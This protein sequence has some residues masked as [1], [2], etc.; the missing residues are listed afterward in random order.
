MKTWINHGKTFFP[1]IDKAAVER[2][3]NC[4]F[5]MECAIKGKNGWTEFPGQIYFQENPPAGYS[6]YFAIFFNLEGHLMITSG[7][8]IEDLIFQGV[9]CPS[10][11][12]I[13]SR[14][15]HDFRKAQSHNVCVDGGFDYFRLV[16]SFESV[17][18]VN[19]KVRGSEIV[20][21]EDD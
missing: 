3:K 1:E 16:G 20:V 7:A 10:G 5:V 4:K 13:Y 15:R 19:L 21:V 2:T 8:F 9:Q 17:K 11:E 6:K 18:H 14:T 12:I